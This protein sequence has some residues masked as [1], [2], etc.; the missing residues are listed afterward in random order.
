MRLNGDLGSQGLDA[1][2]WS[3]DTLFGVRAAL[4]GRWNADQNGA[5]NSAATAQVLEMRRCKLTEH[6]GGVNLHGRRGDW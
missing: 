6:D 3:Y 4:A 2:G 1:M 5:K